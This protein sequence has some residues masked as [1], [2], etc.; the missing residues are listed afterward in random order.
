MS[1]KLGR[2][3]V[4]VTFFFTVFLALLLLSPG[5]AAA[6]ALL[7]SAA[8]HECAH[9]FAL[10][11]FGAPEVTLWL[12][13][14]GARMRAG[15]MDTLPYGAQAAAL[16]AGP[17]ASLLLAGAFFCV[18]RAFSPPW[19][20]KWAQINAALGFAN[21]LPLS[22]LDGG[23]ALVALLALRRKKEAPPSLGR[24]DLI[25]TAVLTALCLALALFGVRA[26]L[27]TAFTCYCAAS[28]ILRE[29]KRKER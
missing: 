3:R 12:L 2:L 8:V 13:P 9:L 28:V 23:A 17:A 16:L 6:G 19:A 7:L 20:L 14:G 1:L 24:S 5:R 11:A 4:R 25:V 27:F 26:E 29:R 15:A 22:F 10:L 18:H 21:L